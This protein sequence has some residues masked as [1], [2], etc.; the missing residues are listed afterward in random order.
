MPRDLRESL[1][2][3]LGARP[4]AVTVSERRSVAFDP[5]GEGWIPWLARPEVPEIDLG[6]W[7]R[8][9]RDQV[10]QRLLERGAILFRGFD[11]GSPASFEVVCRGFSDRLMDYGERSTPRSTVEGKVYTS[12]EY[13]PDQEIPLHNEMSYAASWPQ[14]IFFY[15]PQ[16]AAEGG[17]TP[18]ADSRR[19]YQEID[20]AVRRRFEDLGVMYVR[21]FGSELGLPWREVFQAEDRR[22]VEEY[23]RSAGID[24]EW[25]DGDRLRT[26]AVR[27]AVTVH[28]R[29][30][31]TVWFNQAHLHHLSA[32]PDDVRRDL[33]SV[34]AEDELPFNTCYGDG[35]A[36]EPEA[37]DEVRRALSRCSVA[38][39]WQRGDL[40]L[41]DNVRIAHGRAP[42]QG[43]RRVVVAMAE[44]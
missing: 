12:T 20:P 34:V 22:A 16:P 17:A 13:P 37:L 31:E 24:V 29:S 19:V 3:A 21:N 33:L 23:C 44:S 10:A 32:L 40:L 15:C 25:R 2:R 27:P 9:H 39:P 26:R 36:I 35:S 28:P 42:Y 1:N 18:L 8:D 5:P 11:I 6:A 43:E 7:A 30:G 4:R 14:R 41:L 38:F